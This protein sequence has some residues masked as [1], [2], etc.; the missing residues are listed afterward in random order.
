[1]TVY[2]MVKMHE[3]QAQNLVDYLREEYD[4]VE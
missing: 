1:M 3:D 2:G 4:N